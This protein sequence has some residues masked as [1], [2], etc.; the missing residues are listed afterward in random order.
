MGKAE[1]EALAWWP[2]QAGTCLIMVARTVI[3]GK[4]KAS[5]YKGALDQVSMTA[6]NSSRGLGLSTTGSPEV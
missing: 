2:A 6:K 4:N 1:G 5:A 3:Y